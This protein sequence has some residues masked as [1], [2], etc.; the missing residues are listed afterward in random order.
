MNS[1][2]AVGLSVGLILL[3]LCIGIPVCIVCVVC[4]YTSQRRRRPLVQTRVVATTPPAAG[5]TIVTTS[6]AT[7][8][9][10]PATQPVQQH[11]PVAFKAGPQEAPPPYPTANYPTY[12]PPIPQ[13]YIVRQLVWKVS[14]NNDFV[15]KFYS[16]L[17]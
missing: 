6:Q 4:C 13:V 7:S 11:Y 8:A 16:F 15:I 12:P 1:G 3:F 14:N 5:T 10:A 17:F 9:A 2:L